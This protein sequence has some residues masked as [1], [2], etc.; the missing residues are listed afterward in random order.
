MY[1]NSTVAIP[2]EKGKIILRNK[3]GATYVLYQHGQVYKPDKKYAVPQR[4]IRFHRCCFHTL[5][6]KADSYLTL[7]HI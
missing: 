6:E 7:C 4:T 2:A 5:E 1:L 3:G